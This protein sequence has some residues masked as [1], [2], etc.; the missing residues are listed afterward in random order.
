VVLKIILLIVG[1]CLTA[2]CSKQD[3]AP[4]EYPK[5]TFATAVWER[6]WKRVLLSPDYLRVLQI[7][8][9]CYPFAERLLIINN[10]E[11]LDEVK[12]V[13]SRLVAEGVLTRFVVADEI[14][15]AAFSH[16][17]LSKGDFQAGPSD[18]K[19]DYDDRWLYY[20]ALAPL[21][22]IYACQSEYLLYCTGDVRL[23]KPVNW[24]VSAL[25]ALK[26]N[27]LQ[28]A[29]LA[30][31]GKYKEAKK[32]SSCENEHFYIASAGFSDQL[33]LVKKELFCRPIYREIRKDGGH[34]PRGDVFEKRVF[35]YMK[36]HG[37]KR[38]IFKHGS[39]THE[40]IYE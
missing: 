10:V 28:V 2:S 3:N 22:A 19:R 11:N 36:N 4:Q 30:W 13:A 16:F 5:V 29:N 32:E 21:A 8:N 33:F 1:I 6:D 23:D 27:P 7:Q 14:A 15:E 12:Q 17:Q 18:E 35:S 38:L 9:H 20:N 24:I 37:W 40:N 31:D 34:Y 39:Y 26:K 25:E